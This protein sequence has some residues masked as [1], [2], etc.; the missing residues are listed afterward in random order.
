[1]FNF[2]KALEAGMALQVDLTPEQARDGFER[3][4]VLGVRLGDSADE[5]RD[6]LTQLLEHHLHSRAGLEILPQGTATNNTESGAA[7]YSFRDDP[8]ASFDIFVKQEAQY[9]FEANPLLRRDGQWL[10]DLLSL[11]DELVQ[12]I[13]HAGGT[14]QSDEP[15]RSRSGPARW[16][17][18]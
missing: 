7:G 16:A 15:C 17:T 3:V 8:D 4:I 14:D 13:P 6:N 12:R 5:G 11:P 2:E 9:S 18:R 1:M 10:A